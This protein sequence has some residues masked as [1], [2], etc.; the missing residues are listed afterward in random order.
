MG[1]PK[2]SCCNYVYN[3]AI[4]NSGGIVSMNAFRVT[5]IYP[6]Q[7]QSALQDRRVVSLI[8][9]AKKVEKSMFEVAQSRV[10]VCETCLSLI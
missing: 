6:V 2:I 5:T 3:T 10:S 1:K 8:Q 4:L 7:D 9:Y